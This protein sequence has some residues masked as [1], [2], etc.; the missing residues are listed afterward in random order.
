M[1]AHW[2]GLRGHVPLSQPSRR[3]KPYISVVLPVFNRAH[4]V[5]RAIDSILWQTYS[6]RELIVVDDGSTDGTCDR[7]ASFGERIQV[8]RQANQG[9]SAA[10]NAG[11]RAARGKF[12]AFLD[13]DDE[14]LP[15]K[16]EYQVALTSDERV[17]LS[18]TNWRSKEPG[19]SRTGFDAL[20]FE[21]PWICDCPAQL[22]SRPGG[23]HIMLSSWLVR[24]D[25]LLALGGFNNT[26]ALAEDN[27]LLFRLSFVGRFA[28]TKRVLLFRETAL[29]SVKLSRPGSQKYH[30]ELARAMCIALANARVLA[31]GE[32][33]LVQRQFGRMYAYWLRKE[34]EFAALDGRNWATRRLALEA[35]VH[36]PDSRSA[37]LACMGT[38]FPPF[39]R[40]RM[41]R[42]YPT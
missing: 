21:E 4:C 7:L 19:D 27:D 38:V 11:I 41:R 18:A 29:D 16:L 26:L 20:A 30:R 23:H 17:V 28:L 35:L 6:D 15:E 14:W 1:T 22:V 25:A 39:I 10:R 24:R 31:F 9:P 40:W 42:K 34:M 36:H 2:P 13:S 37:L 3:M 33:A 8:I 32:S 12:I 5:G